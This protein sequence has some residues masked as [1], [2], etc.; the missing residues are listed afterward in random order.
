[1]AGQSIDLDEL[2]VRLRETD[3]IPSQQALIDDL[4]RRFALLSR[5][6][7]SNVAALRKQL[8]TTDSLDALA[9]RSEVD[10]AYLVLLRRALRGFFPKPRAFKDVR[11]LDDGVVASLIDAGI[12]NTVRFTEAASGDIAGLQQQLHLSERVLSDVTAVCDLCRVQWVSPGFAGALIAAGYR[13]AEA[14]AAADPETVHS[15]VAK[16]NAQSTY[17]NGSVGLR[18]IE[19]VIHAARYASWTDRH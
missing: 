19:R 5:A 2:R 1:M 6:G 3:L 13:T 15:A 7:L 9:E 12:K 10:T 14:L 4:D 18:D 8:E 17:Y 11:W 16:A